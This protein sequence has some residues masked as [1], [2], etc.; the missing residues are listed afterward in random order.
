[1]KTSVFNPCGPS[2]LFKLILLGDSGVGKTSLLLRYLDNT[3]FPT[4]LTNSTIAVD[5]RTKDIPLN[6]QTIRCQFWDTA[7]QE[8]YKALNSGYYRGAAAVFIVFGLDEVGAVEGVRRWMREVR[9]EVGGGV[10]VYL[11]GTKRD[12]ERGVGEQEVRGVMEEEEG[13]GIGGYWEVSAKTGEGVEE[14][15]GEVV[16]RLVGSGRESSV[17]TSKLRPE[18]ESQKGKCQC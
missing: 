16:R 12:L 10:E 9:E 14:M 4:S 3:F 17:M 5:F 13:V 8:K 15:F 6:S 11:V 1:M 18:F 2:R 7:G